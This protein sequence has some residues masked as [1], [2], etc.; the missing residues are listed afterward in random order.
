MEYTKVRNIKIP[1]LG[2][3]SWL[4]GDDP[5]EKQR[6]IATFEYGY[7]NHQMTL[8]DTAEM[9]GEGKSERVVG[10]FLKGQNRNDFFIVDKILPSNASQG[11]Y[12]ERC[13]NSLRIMGLDYFDLYLLHWK[14][15]VD[16]QDMVNNMEHLKEI[17][18]IKEWGV[19]NFD[20]DAMEQLFKC[21]HGNRCFANQCLFNLNARGVEFDLI[22]WCQSHDVLFMAYSPLG[23]NKEDRERVT[24]NEQFKA[25]AIN[26]GY[27]PASL[28]LAFAMREDKVMAIFKTSSREHLDENM[29]NVFKPVDDHLYDE[30]NQVFPKTNKKKRLETI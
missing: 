15:N 19:S 30:I 7:K 28:M 21:H 22:P 17:G 16:L 29:R 2:F 3:G 27:T 8:I 1:K 11:L 24:N 23:N 18:L 25:L 26:N 6:E 5:D 14:S 4:I 13:R 9:Y 20:V 10:E 12:E